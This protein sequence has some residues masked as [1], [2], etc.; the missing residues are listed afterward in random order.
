MRV[1]FDD[2]NVS[3]LFALKKKEE[4]GC[5]MINCEWLPSLTRRGLGV[6]VNL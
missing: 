5:S 4:Q 6:H 1:V 3:V 2:S